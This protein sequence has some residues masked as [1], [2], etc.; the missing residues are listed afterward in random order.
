MKIFNLPDLGEG[1]PDAEI[2]EWQ[3]KEGD[4][5]VADQIMVSMETAKAVVDVPAPYN[6][7]VAKLYGQP[8]D[9]IETG[10]P[11]IS[12]KSTAA[13]AASAPAETEATSKSSATETDSATDGAV[14]AAP[15]IRALA[16]KLNVD[17]TTITPSG[18]NGQISK[19]DVEQAAAST[20]AQNEMSTKSEAIRGVRRAMVQSMTLAH[21]AVAQVT[22]VDDADIHGWSE[23]EDITA[24]IVR[25]LCRACEQEPALN[26]WFNAEKLERTLH[27]SVNL[28][29]AMD[30]GEGLFVPVIK[31]AQDL[32]PQALRMQI[33]A[34]KAAVKDRSLAPERLTG[35][36][37]SLSNFGVFAGR[38]ANPIVVPPTVAIIGVG[39][40]RA[41]A[42]AVN[43]QVE[44]HRRLPLSVSV[45]HRCVTGAEASHF[46]AAMIH[47]LQHNA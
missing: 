11:L 17:L 33:N 39:K 34:D 3:V 47:D 46:L 25:A 7:V 41:D 23:T 40:I 27:R 36:T 21:Q 6:G 1:L 16:K 19:E 43:G 45:D 15:A 42:V 22:L 2:H 24:R 30:A 29:L 35:A 31:E 38:Y 32:T 20:N 9:I 18:T 10:A 12:F 13:A 26:A 14:K 44:I 8:G 5:V 4:T 37:I 28:G